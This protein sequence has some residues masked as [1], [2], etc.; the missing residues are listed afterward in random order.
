MVLRLTPFD[1]VET[2]A[3]QSENLPLM[4]NRAQGTTHRLGNAASAVR[5]ALPRYAE[6]IVEKSWR[7]LSLLAGLQPI[8]TTIAP[9]SAWVG[10]SAWLQHVLTQ[11]LQ[12]QSINPELAD[13]MQLLNHSDVPLPPMSESLAPFSANAYSYSTALSARECYDLV[14]FESLSAGMNKIV[15]NGYTKAQRDNARLRAET[16]AL[17]LGSTLIAT[18]IAFAPIL[19]SR[20]RQWISRSATASSPDATPE[21]RL[22]RLAHF[23][24]QAFVWSR[25]ATFSGLTS[26]AAAG[27]YYLLTLPTTWQSS[28][29]ADFLVPPFCQLREQG[30]P[31]PIIDA[32]GYPA[33]SPDDCSAQERQRLSLEDFQAD[34]R[35]HNL[36]RQWLELSLC[37]F[38]L[39][40]FAMSIS[41]SAYSLTHTMSR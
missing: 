6:I 17:A 40:A 32:L 30:L 13:C 8:A 36:A 12:P 31:P 9:A 39:A 23:L 29:A 24:Q 33:F 19:N 2:R 11:Q 7:A 37:A 5:Q 34:Y 27:L 26:N 41:R 14:T 4:T 21:Q 15:E 1:G 28:K 38:L 3:S 16:G 25:R 18:I 35:L 10:A 22:A 20:V